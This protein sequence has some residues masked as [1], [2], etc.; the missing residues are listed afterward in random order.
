[1]YL[2]KLTDFF[3]IFDSGTSLQVWEYRVIKV[4]LPEGDE[5]VI[6]V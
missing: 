3:S 1:M 5:L 6:A 4:F 2:L